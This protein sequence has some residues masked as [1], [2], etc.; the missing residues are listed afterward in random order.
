MHA[1]HVCCDAGA[2]TRQWWLADGVVEL[3]VIAQLLS[4]RPGDAGIL[5][6][7]CGAHCQPSGATQSTTSS[8]PPQTP[9]CI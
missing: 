9:K 6:V 7:R 2:T 1:R 5:R 8:R 4:A 3:E